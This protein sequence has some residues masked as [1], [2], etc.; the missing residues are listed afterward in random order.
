MVKNGMV[1]YVGVGWYGMVQYGVVW[2]FKCGIML[3]YGT[4][5]YV[6]KEIIFLL[7]EAS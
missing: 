4:V 5:R 7:S 1:W 2:Q 3:W 6:I